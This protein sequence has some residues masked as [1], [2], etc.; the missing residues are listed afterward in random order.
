MYK[1]YEGS[2]YGNFRTKKFTDYYSS[3]SDFLNDY[4]NVGIPATIDDT[5][6]STLYY[7][8]YARYGNSRIASSDPTRF[9]YN[10]F[11]IIWQFGPNWVKKLDIQKTLRDLTETEL[12]EG[13]RQI[14][15]SAANPSINPSNFTDDE[16]QY[17]NSQ[18]V[19]KAR[20][21]KLDGYAVL[22][23]LLEDDVTEELLSRFKK[24]FLT[25]VMPEL[26]LWYESEG[27]D[28]ND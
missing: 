12:L 13:S 23:S 17:I 5:N 22:M 9:K 8:L 25:I 27:E 10:L 15:N 1:S 21:G 28:E 18:N 24:L 16:I 6:A 4:H 19:T 14:Y 11:S 26:P 3:V 7:L 20:K 2:L